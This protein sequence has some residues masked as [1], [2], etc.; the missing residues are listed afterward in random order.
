[1]SSLR[2][3][4]CLRWRIFAGVARVYGIF[5]SS[6]CPIDIYDSSPCSTFARCFH[7][8]MMLVL[9]I[10]PLL[11]AVVVVQLEVE[12]ICEL[13]TKMQ[14]G[15]AEPVEMADD[16]DEETK[17]SIGVKVTVPPT[18]SDVL[19]AVDVIEDVAIAYGFNR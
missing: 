2:T 9:S 5:V 3:P 16:K 10:L 19:H 15:P 18:R 13:C 17:S 12:E 6:P 7:D 14:L 4:L 8:A 1:M 11:L